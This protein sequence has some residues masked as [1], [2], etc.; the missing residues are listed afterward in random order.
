L[1]EPQSGSDASDLRTQATRVERINP[2]TKKREVGYTITGSKRW[3]GNGS[4]S[5][6]YVVWAR[7]M[8]LS[9]NPVMGFIVQK[10]HQQHERAI[11]TSK[12]EGK[13]SMRMLQ[14]ANVEFD[15]A[16][17]PD[18]NVMYDHGKSWKLSLFV[19]GTGDSSNFLHQS[20]LPKHFSISK[21]PM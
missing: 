15:D 11:R 21:S 10:S 19:V 4:S 17:C 3:I 5:E 12:I 2:L 1:T 20:R 18:A 9:G 7:N 13:V 6:V 14:N 8:A 16:W